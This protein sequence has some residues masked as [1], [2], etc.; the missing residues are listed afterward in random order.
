VLLHGWQGGLIVH[1][2][3]MPSTSHSFK[4]SILQKKRGRMV[5]KRREEELEE[6]RDK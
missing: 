2:S 5:G 1:T 3:A 4:P 6:W